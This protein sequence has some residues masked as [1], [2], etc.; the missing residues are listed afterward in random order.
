MCLQT[1]Q[2]KHT[3]THTSTATFSNCINSTSLNNFL[4]PVTFYG[5]NVL[6]DTSKNT[7]VM[8]WR[9]L[10]NVNTLQY[11]CGEYS[12]FTAFNEARGHTIERDFYLNHLRK[13]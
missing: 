1:L 7:V 3:H 5:M 8:M 6:I 12:L 9:M 13:G 4:L 11:V 2:A 10:S